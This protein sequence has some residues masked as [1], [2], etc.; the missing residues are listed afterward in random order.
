MLRWSIFIHKWLGLI[1]GLQ[2]LGWVLGGVVMTAIPIERV[3]GEHRYAAYQP[4]P[5]PV[6]GV[7]DLQGAAKAAGVDAVEATIKT[8]LRGT[9]WMLKDAEGKVHTVDALTGRHMPPLTESEARLLAGSV[10]QGKGRPAAVRF[11][12]EAPRETGK[13]GPLWRVDFD[14]AERTAFYLS[15]DTGEVVSKRSNVWRFY[16]FFWRIHILDFKTGD[17]FNHPLIIAAAALSLPMTIAGLVLLC[18]R[19]GRD[20]KAMRARNRPRPSPSR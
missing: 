14:D 16:D 17:N 11:H 3:R 12:R 19:L 6:S 1:V 7:L 5:L 18:I 13:A 9:V 8:T 4:M 20:L 2:V 10:Y 15:P